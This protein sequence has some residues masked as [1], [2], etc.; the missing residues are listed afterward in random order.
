MR[1][2][3][4][5]VVAD[6][7]QELEAALSAAG[8]VVEAS[9]EPDQAVAA[10]AA[11]SADAVVVPPGAWA[12]LAGSHAGRGSPGALSPRELDVL[13]LVA[14]GRENTEIAQ[15]LVISPKTVKNHLSSILAKLGLA[16]RV[17][18]AVWA[19]R[20]GIAQP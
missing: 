5:V 7:G 3:R 11:A 13:R 4:V 1:R 15:A 12:M 9:V 16:N 18:A 17:Q 20:A 19:V 14:Q 6:A 10:A 8:V 2:L